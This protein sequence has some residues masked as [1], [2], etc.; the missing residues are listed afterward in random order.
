MKYEL[1]QK[2]NE[3]N[4]AEME[5]LHALSRNQQERIKG[6]EET[7][8]SQKLLFDQLKN[9]RQS[10]NQSSVHKEDGEEM[11]KLHETEVN[12]LRL[13]IEEFRKQNAE[14]A[15]EIGELQLQL[16]D[17]ETQLIGLKE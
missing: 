13:Q 10:P 5:N 2:K 1:E 6:L 17:R 7:L 15:N 8:S 16:Q 14:K 12:R 3:L 4:T 9:I 11:S